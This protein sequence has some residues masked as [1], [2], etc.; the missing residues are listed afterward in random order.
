MSKGK[1]LC[2]FCQGVTFD[3]NGVTNRGSRLMRCDECDEP[4]T[5]WPEGY[6][7][8]L[9]IRQ[10]AESDRDRAVEALKGYVPHL[11]PQCRAAAEQWDKARN[12]ITEIKERGE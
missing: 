9:S 4:S 2:A 11:R 1:W 12:L 6:P 8:K 3:V 5:C 10:Q 7:F